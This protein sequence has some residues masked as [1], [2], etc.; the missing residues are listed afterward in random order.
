MALTLTSAAFVHHT[1]IPLL[2]TCDGADHSPPLRWTDPP[3]GTQ[4]FVLLVDDPDAPVGHWV[5]WVVYNVPAAS[6][7]LPAHLPTTETLPDGTRQ[8]L[9]DF[10]RIGYGG[11]CPP[12][13]PAHRYVFAL[14]ALDTTLTL[15]VKTTKAHVEQAITGHLLAQTDLIGRYQR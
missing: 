3:A 13:G 9:N 12:R 6:R 8:G 14:Y 15:P 1:S 5:H 4:S 7:S 10:R 11:P 2:Y